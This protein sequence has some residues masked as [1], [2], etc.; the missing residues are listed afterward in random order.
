[1]GVNVTLIVQ[2]A[3]T[4][5]EVVEQLSVSAKSPV[6]EMLTLVT[7]ICPLFVT[8]TDWAAAV[9]PVVV[10]AKVKLVGFSVMF[11]E[12]PLALRVTVC[13]LP[14][15]LSLIVRVPERS[16]TCEAFTATEIVQL[17]PGA[18]D[19]PQVFELVKSPPL[20]VV[21]IPV[22]ESGAVPVFCN[23]TW[24]GVPSGR[25]VVRV[26]SGT[27]P[28]FSR[29]AETTATGSVPTPVKVTVEACC[30]PEASRIFKLPVCGPVERGVKVTPITQ[31]LPA[32][33]WAPQLA[34]GEGSCTT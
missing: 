26:L 15:A 4:P 7:V 16:P 20:G 8:V 31:E 17:A 34:A 6:M 18:S 10:C 14:A 2:D 13:G 25:A 3:P 11:P 23:V 22:M 21:V 9:V 29:L 32:A 24:A 19:A 28:K 1:V 33:S 30:T 12:T 5:R 27:F